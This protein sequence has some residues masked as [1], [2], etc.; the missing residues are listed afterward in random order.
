MRL[1]ALIERHWRKLI[2]VFGEIVD[3]Y[4]MNESVKDETTV[5]M[6]M[7]EEPPYWTIKN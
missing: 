1:W 2:D 5:R 6:C 3:A 7:K 4:T